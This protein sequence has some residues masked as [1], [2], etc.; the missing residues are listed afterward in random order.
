M[1]VE[2]LRHKEFEKKAQKTRKIILRMKLLNK[3]RGK[4]ET[5][6]RKRKEDSAS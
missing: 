4:E 6:Y 1:V 5:G 2:L 3:S